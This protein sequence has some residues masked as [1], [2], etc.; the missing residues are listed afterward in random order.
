[1]PHA[2]SASAG[3]AL[4]LA[5]MFA[6]CSGDATVPDEPSRPSGILYTGGVQRS[7]LPAIA[8]DV[9]T[10]RFDTLDIPLITHSYPTVSSDG[11]WLAFTQLGK[12]FVYKLSNGLARD[13]TNTFADF[14]VWWHPDGQRVLVQR[15]PI[16]FAR[17]HFVLVNIDRSGE[18]ELYTI[19]Q[20]RFVGLTRGWSPDGR[21]LYFAEN[22]DLES[23]LLR[24]D[25]TTAGAVP[26]TVGPA[27]TRVVSVSPSTGDVA[28]SYFP[29]GTDSMAVGVMNPITQ[30]VS[31][32]R[33]YW[34][35]ANLAW[36]P[37]GRYLAVLF[38]DGVSPHGSLDILNSQTGAI[39]QRISEFAHGSDVPLTWVAGPP[40]K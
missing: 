5:L 21:Y 27:N 39:V 25:I 15:T 12:V 7:T 24:L 38:G 40:S 10:G 14:L 3:W 22:H 17:P 8:V 34:L 20:D 29:P 2:R 37:D 13:I 6:A 32:R 9:V 36:S 26:D 31:N 16:G 1:M 33:T 11:E 35:V 19:P 30:A 28:V 4:S 23:A 18:R